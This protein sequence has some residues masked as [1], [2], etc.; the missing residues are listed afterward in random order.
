MIPTKLL[1]Q[2]LILDTSKILTDNFFSGFKGHLNDILVVVWC[3]KMEDTEDIFPSRLN[4]LSLRG[5]DLGDAAH[6]HVLYHRRPGDTQNT[7][8]HFCLPTHTLASLPSNMLNLILTVSLK[9][10]ISLLK[11]RTEAVIEKSLCSGITNIWWECY[12]R[13]DV[14]HPNKWFLPILFQDVFKWT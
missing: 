10:N 5:D 9:S 12:V 13:Q 4:I 6:H 11:Q 2:L 14:S 3:G 8:Q 1:L 7:V